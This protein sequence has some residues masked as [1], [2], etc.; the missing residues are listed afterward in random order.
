MFYTRYYF[1]YLIE[2]KN[3]YLHCSLTYYFIFYLE[4]KEKE[5][6][7]ITISFENFKNTKKLLNEL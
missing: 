5:Y 2:F 1:L 6:S 7:S 3:I 4:L